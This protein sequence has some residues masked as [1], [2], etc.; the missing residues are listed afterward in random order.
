MQLRSGRKTCLNAAPTATATASRVK[1]TKQVVEE[2]AEILD[3][4]EELIANSI[5]NYVLDLSNMKNKKKEL[6]RYYGEDEYWSCNARLIIELTHIMSDNL[7]YISENPK[8]HEFIIYDTIDLLSKY[9]VDFLRAI[10]KVDF[11]YNDDIL[12]NNVINDI[13]N[14]IKDVETRFNDYDV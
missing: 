3:P 14:F 13:N 4:R 7:D 8:W 12:M 5:H 10:R 6:I 11:E 1:P 2:P 9:K